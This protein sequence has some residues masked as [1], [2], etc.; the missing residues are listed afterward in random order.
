MTRIL[1]PEES[2]LFEEGGWPERRLID[3]LVEW[4]DRHAITEPIVVT[5]DTGEILFALTQGEII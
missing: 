3:D 1:T 2:A 4:A 5:L